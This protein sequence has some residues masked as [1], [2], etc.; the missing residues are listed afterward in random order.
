MIG[1]RNGKYNIINFVDIQNLELMLEDLYDQ[2][3]EYYY[4]STSSSETTSNS[5][6]TSNDN[7]YEI[8]RRNKEENL[9]GLRNYKAQVKINGDKNIKVKSILK[10]RNF[11]RKKTFKK[12]EFGKIESSF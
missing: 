11:N 3:I 4:Y 8:K 5:K 7:A 12:V 9:F 2:E 10:Q 6:S 1:T